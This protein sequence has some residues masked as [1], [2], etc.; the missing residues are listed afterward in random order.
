MLHKLYSPSG[1]LQL[2]PI[3]SMKGIF[4]GSRM[5]N[6]FGFLEKHPQVMMLIDNQA[7]DRVT[8][9]TIVRLVRR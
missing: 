9:N 8:W 1:V 4:L 7:V 2:M 5:E 6:I 3:K